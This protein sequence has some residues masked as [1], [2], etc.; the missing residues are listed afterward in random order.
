MVVLPEVDVLL[1]RDV[2]GDGRGV[3]RISWRQSSPSN[4]HPLLNKSR[5]G[6]EPVE[7]S[8]KREACRQA[9]RQAQREETHRESKSRACEC[10]RA[11]PL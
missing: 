2:L 1:A 4:P 10:A 9:G 5:C 3:R 7:E 8:R 11:R 6:V